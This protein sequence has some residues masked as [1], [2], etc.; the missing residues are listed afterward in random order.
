MAEKERKEAEPFE[1]VRD[2]ASAGEEMEDGMVGDVGVM[3]VGIAIGLVQKIE[4]EE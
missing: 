1:D 4:V 2:G 3:I